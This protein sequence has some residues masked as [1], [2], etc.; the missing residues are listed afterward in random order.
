M[1]CYRWRN[2]LSAYFRACLEIMKEITTSLRKFQFLDYTVRA[3]RVLH[4]Q[5]MF[6]IYILKCNKTIKNIEK[7]RD[8]IIFLDFN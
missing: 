2:L 6:Y 7:D 3:L 8:L 1:Y 5:F 4:F